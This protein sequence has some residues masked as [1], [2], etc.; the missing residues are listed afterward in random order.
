MAQPAKWAGSLGLSASFRSRY[1]FSIIVAAFSANSVRQCG[2]ST[3][4]AMERLH[5][6]EPVGARI[7][8][9]VATGTGNSF[10][11]YCHS[12]ADNSRKEWGIPLLSHSSP[13]LPLIRNSRQENNDPLRENIEIKKVFNGFSSSCLPNRLPLVQLS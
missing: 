1:L 11:W 7:S 6:M 3:V 8:A 13:F 4:F 12:G 5:G 2:G 9:Q 10:L